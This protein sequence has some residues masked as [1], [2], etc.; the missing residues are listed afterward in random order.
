M[1]KDRE[2]HWQFACP[3]CGFG[4]AEIGALAADDEIY[5]LVC[6]EEAGRYIILHRWPAESVA[7]EQ[8]LLSVRRIAA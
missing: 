6:L 8:A 1:P 5:C 2:T 7:S 3:E 4:H